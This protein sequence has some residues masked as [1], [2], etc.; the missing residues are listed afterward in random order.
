MKLQTARRR[1]VTR[2]DASDT[3]FLTQQLESLDPTTYYELVPSRMG[4]RFIP[5]VENVAPFDE[6]YKYTMT[7]LKGR[8]RKSAPRSKAAPS[9]EVTKTEHNQSIKT[10]DTSFGWTVDEIKAAK[11]KNLNLDR[12]RY[13]AAV[14]GIEQ[15]IDDALALGIPE[16]NAYGLT[17][18]PNVQTTNPVAKTGGGTSWLGAGVKPSEII[19]D[20]SNMIADTRAL[21]KSARVPGSDQP[22]FQKFTLL[23]PQDHLTVIATTPR[24]DN[25]DTTILEWVLT[26]MRR[27]IAGIEDWW[28]LDAADGGDPMAVMYPALDSG[29]MNPFAGGGILPMDFETLNPQE[30]GRDIVIPAAGKCGGVVMRYPLAYRYMKTL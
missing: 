6:A 9:V 20:I 19:K 16:I 24:S 15:Q 4:R 5:P 17:N 23:L 18:N 29:A 14:I 3:Y 10:F 22:V 25:S 11:A 2:L 27:W 28:Q 30:D 12:D 13:A 21:L 7:H 1:Q 8:A 26:N